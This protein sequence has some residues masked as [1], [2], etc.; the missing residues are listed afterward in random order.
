[1]D[2]F[3][4]RTAED[5]SANGHVVVIVLRTIIRTVI[6]KIKHIKNNHTKKIVIMTIIRMV[7]RY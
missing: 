3:H 4:D 5:C 7:S 6:M 1:M 2:Y